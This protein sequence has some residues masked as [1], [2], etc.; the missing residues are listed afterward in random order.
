[1]KRCP[2]CRRDYFDDSLLYCLDDGNLLLEGPGT[3]ETPTA[4]LPISNISSDAATAVLRSPESIASEG[5]SIA[6]LPFA[7]LG[8]GP[9]DEFFCEGLAEE[10]LNSLSKIDNLKVAARTSAFSFRGKNTNVAEI[11]RVLGVNTVLEGSVRRSAEKLRITIKLINAADGYQIWSERYD[12]EMRDVFDLQDDIAADVCERLRVGISATDIQTRR[13]RYTENSEAYPLYLKGRYFVTTKRTEEWI[14]KGIECFQKAIDLDPA[15]ALAYAGLA[16]AYGFL[17]SSTGG[18]PPTEA[19]PKA[20][21]AAERALEIDPT[22]GEARTSLGFYYLLYEWDMKRAG[23][24][25]QKAVELAPK[26]TNAHD[27]MGFYYKAIGRFDDAIRHCNRVLELDPLSPFGYVSLGWGYYFARAFDQAIGE[28]QKALELEPRHSF[29]Y[30]LMG[31]SMV[32][33]GE[34]DQA[35]EALEKAAANSPGAIGFRTYAAYAYARA[36]RTADA[37]EVINIL[38]SA[39]ADRYVSP[40]YFSLIHVGLNEME[41]AFQWLEA[42]VAERSGF[43]AFLGVEPTLDPIRDDAR[44]QRVVE[45]SGLQVS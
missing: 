30:Q 1:M 34:L 39:K 16:D 15:Y 3:A 43:I 25:F 29:A 9:E 18:W 14:K 41:T 36:G 28:C 4:F 12:R 45:R 21:V 6:V 7:C 35:V 42:A 8:S 5:N 44:F 37:E 17:A 11:G 27:G 22:L 38:E 23:E 40:Y 32:Q 24:E 20:K 19:Y 10:L 2:E 26:L 13:R 31:L 33:I